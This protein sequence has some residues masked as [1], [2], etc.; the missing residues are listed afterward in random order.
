MKSQ[1]IEQQKTAAMFDSLRSELGLTGELGEVEFS[2]WQVA[3]PGRHWVYSAIASVI[4]AFGLSMSAL[5]EDS[6]KG[7]VSVDTSLAALHLNGL[8]HQKLNGVAWD[9]RRLLTEVDGITGFYSSVNGRLVFIVATYLG[10]RKKLKKELG[11]KTLSH[12]E[13]AHAVS[14]RDPFELEYKLSRSG[15]CVAA[16]RTAEEW[17]GSA[18]GKYLQDAPLV[19]SQFF[20][21]ASAQP[22]GTQSS[23]HPLNGVRVIDFTHVVAG[24]LAGKNLAQYGAEVIRVS[25]GDP[26][27]DTDVPEVLAAT[28][29]GKEHIIADLRTAQGRQRIESLI[30]SSDVL[31]D[32]WRPGTLE[33]FGFGPEKLRELRP[34]LIYVGV[35]AYGSQGEMSHW[36]GFDQNAQT[37]SGIAHDE[38]GHLVPTYLFNDYFLGYLAAAAIV[39]AL[40]RR[41]IRGGSSV[42]H[43]NLTKAA[44]WL[45]SFGL[46]E[47]SP[48]VDLSQYQRFEK[49]QLE[50]RGTLEYL[51]PAVQIEGASPIFPTQTKLPF[52]AELTD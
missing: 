23:V 29:I 13:V 11:L 14:Q 30:A 21:D 28:V 18:Q 32:S 42:L 35:N 24:P 40:R 49:T 38:G 10:L 25:S 43:L 41:S 31:I 46:K 12:D 47:Q 1:A 50:T 15:L 39:A 51:A 5:K 44:M 6:P 4:G 37:L 3:S 20:N 19:E 7:K 2:P 27:Y 22:V 33:K 8:D 9:V 48:V 16:L 26:D 52:A 17:R 34:G 45:Q 36:G